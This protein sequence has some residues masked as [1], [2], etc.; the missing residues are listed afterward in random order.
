MLRRLLPPAAALL[1]TFGATSP[2]SAAAMYVP[3]LQAGTP[4][5]MTV[6][7]RSAAPVAAKLR[8]A[9]VGSPM[10][11]LEGP[12]GI[13]HQFKLEGLKPGAV[14]TYEGFDGSAAV[15]G[16]TF[17]TNPAAGTSRFRFA[18]IGDTG[19]GTRHQLA[20]A[21]Q[22]TAWKPDFVLHVGDVIYERGED[23]NFGPR[24]FAPYGALA[25]RSVIYLSP[26]NHDYGNPKAANYF[27]HF[28]GPRASVADSER[29]YTTTYG[30]AQ[31]FGLDTNQPFGEGSVQYR[32]L[33]AQ[34]AASR[35]PWKFAFFHHPPYSGGEH[36]GSPYVRAAFGPLFEAHDVQVVFAGHDHHYERMKPIDDFAHDGRPTTYL[37]SGGG[38]A[39]LRRAQATA[40]TAF[41]R[42]A[43]HFLG[44]EVAGDRLTGSAIGEDGKAFDTWSVNK[45]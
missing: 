4:T 22:M 10:R 23:V 8:F 44:V 2:G 1:A 20:V 12:A 39:W 32:W 15:G 36:G 19:S 28:E 38:G 37:V 7:W 34:L 21:E 5:S 18:V 27:A 24:F 43:Y 33:A 31:I 40:K 30:D 42:S 9:L 3:Y 29:W 41:V 13:W 11:E 14:Y 16:G 25:A 35:A 17:R 45:N 26:G 6:M